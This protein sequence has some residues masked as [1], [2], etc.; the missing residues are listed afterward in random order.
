MK[1]YTQ[2]SLV[3][4]NLVPI[5]GIL[6]LDW[7]LFSVLF[8]Y[9]LESAVV[10]IYNIPKM[11]LINPTRQNKNEGTNSA[12]KSHKLS[13]IVFFTIHYS[14]FMAGHGFFI[15]ALFSPVTNGLIIEWSH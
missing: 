6:F 5:P 2:Y 13:G 15:F 8:F 11:M 14:G 9:W 3:L 1:K 4:A 10:G 7:N 12:I